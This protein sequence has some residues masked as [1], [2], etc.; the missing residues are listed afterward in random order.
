MTPKSFLLGDITLKFLSKLLLGTE[1]RTLKLDCKDNYNIIRAVGSTNL[2]P[3]TG[4][5]NH[6]LKAFIFA[7]I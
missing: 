6:L 5:V 2:K 3:R 1:K 7:I 4:R